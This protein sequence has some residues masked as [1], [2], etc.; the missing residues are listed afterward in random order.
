MKQEQLSLLFVS[1]FC[2]RPLTASPSKRKLLQQIKT[3]ELISKEDES[4]IR[5]GKKT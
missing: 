4:E 3:I 1:L 2:A 5:K